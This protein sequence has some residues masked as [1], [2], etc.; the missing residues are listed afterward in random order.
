MTPE[1]KKKQLTAT[2]RE[3][4][5]WSEKREIMDNISK[6]FG[7]DYVEKTSKPLFSSE[8]AENYLTDL[9]LCTKPENYGFYVLEMMRRVF[10]DYDLSMEFSSE[11]VEKFKLRFCEFISFFGK[12]PESSNLLADP[13]I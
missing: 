11:S 6:F 8:I 1:E 10:Y 13:F 5:N 7:R 9:P 3:V 2:I 4:L 12:Q